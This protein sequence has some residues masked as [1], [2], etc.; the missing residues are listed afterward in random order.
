MRKSLEPKEAQIEKL[1]EDLCK[2]EG[3]LD[4]M[5]KGS[6]SQNDT[7]K[8]MKNQIETLNKTLKAQTETTT[9]KD[10]KLNQIIMDIHNI[11]NGV[12]MKQWNNKLMLLYQTYVKEDTTLKKPTHD[13]KGLDELKSHVKHLEKSIH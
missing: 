8:K 12:D 3:E 9:Q 6:Q 13:P 1:K 7:T 10:N 5:I 2:L 11:V 4:G